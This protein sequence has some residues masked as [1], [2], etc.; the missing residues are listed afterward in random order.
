MAYTPVTITPEELNAL[1]TEH[2]DIMRFDGDPD[3]APWIVIVRR[4]KRQEAIAFKQH[5]TRDI[6][7]ANEAL[8]RRITVFPKGDDLEKMFDRWH[9]LCDGIASSDRFKAFIGL[10]VGSQLK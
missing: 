10:A 3:L 5:A 8:V 1:E 6:A 4:P 7:T 2:E 9:M